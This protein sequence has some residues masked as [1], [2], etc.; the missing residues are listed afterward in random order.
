MSRNKLLQRLVLMH[1]P[2]DRFTGVQVEDSHIVLPELTV[3]PDD[4]VLAVFDEGHEI[5]RT[6]QS[7]FQEVRAQHKL[8]LSDVSQSFLL[9]N[10]YP[11][12]R[13]VNL[14]EVVR[15]TQRIVFG[16]NTFQLQD[17][18]PTTCLGTTGPPLKSFIFEMPEGYMMVVCMRSLPR[19]Q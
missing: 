15:S 18:E 11:E 10:N 13:R 5:F 2:Y 8:I 1:A 9:Q 4:L 14:T 17:D 7:I 19:T 12:M 3:M 16:A 6:N